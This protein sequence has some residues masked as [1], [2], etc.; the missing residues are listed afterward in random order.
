MRSLIRSLGLVGLLFGAGCASTNTGAALA[1]APASVP[2]SASTIVDTAV[3]AGN[4]STLVRAVQAAGLE[5]TLR[6]AGPF[7]VLA[8]TDAAFNA[9]PAG[10]LA[11]LLLPQNRDRL[12]SVL[13]YHVISGDVRAA[14]VSTMTT[15]N[16]VNGAAVAISATGGAVQIGGATVTRAD[17][18][19]SNGVI[20][21]IDRVLLPPT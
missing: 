19:C 1:S 18:A 14:Q 2:A 5:E 10:A 8:P 16:T 4:F 21:V 17:I 11:E 9:L 3:A 12:R 20:H 15:A 7:T 13:L 6:G